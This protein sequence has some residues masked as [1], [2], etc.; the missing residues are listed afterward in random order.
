M[1]SGSKNI[2]I[3]SIFIISPEKHLS[4]VSHKKTNEPY[5]IP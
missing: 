3:R 1:L 4:Q 5:T 2:I